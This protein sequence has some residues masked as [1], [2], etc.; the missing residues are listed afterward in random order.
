MKHGGKRKRAGRPLKQGAPVSFK[1]KL[2]LT[3]Q[4]YALVEAS[5]PADVDFS[6]WVRTLLLEQVEQ[7]FARALGA[8]HDV[9]AAHKRTP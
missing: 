8:S 3:A 1:F 7:E 5:R 2:S 9:R 6:V 4:E